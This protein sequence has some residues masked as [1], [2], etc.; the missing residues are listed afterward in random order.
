MAFHHGKGA[1]VRLDDSVGGSLT[2]YS[3]YFNDAS[4]SRSIETAETTT[5]GDDDKEYIV[6]LRDATVSL[7]GMFDET[8][9]GVLEG[10]L[11]AGLFTWEVGPM[12]QGTTG[13]IIYSGEGI[14]TSY[15][16][17]PAVGDVVPMS[18]EI[19]CSGAITRTVT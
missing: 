12:G 6:G 9:D 13:D 18:V 14:V 11:G 16:V 1:S 19:Q 15:D 2:D 17:S 3:Q 7:S 4:V 5:F 10:L 8:M